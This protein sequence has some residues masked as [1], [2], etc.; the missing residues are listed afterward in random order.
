MF[1]VWKRDA[2]LPPKTWI[3]A[4]RL[5]A[6]TRAY[7][8]ELLMAE[9]VV[10]DAVGNL[11]VVLVSSPDSGS[12]RAF[13]RGGRELV[14]GPSDQVLLD[15]RSG[16]TFEVREHAL[17]PAGKDGLPLRRIPGHRAY[18]FGWFAFFPDTT[19]Y[20]GCLSSRAGAR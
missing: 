20:E 16:E 10:N 1:P 17:V 12:V 13:E 14:E 18:W 4:L 11:D 3:Y 15:V 9:R 2:R 5:G 6:A 7:P 19:L 8:L